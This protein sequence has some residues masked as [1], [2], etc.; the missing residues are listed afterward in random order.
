MFIWNRVRA[1]SAFLA[2][3]AVNLNDEGEELLEHDA[4]TPPPVM[5]ESD[6]V[7]TLWLSHIRYNSPKP[8]FQEE[9]RPGLPDVVQSSQEGARARSPPPDEQQIPQHQ[10]PLP[11]QPPS[12]ESLASS[13]QLK[14]GRRPQ[15]VNETADCITLSSDEDEGAQNVNIALGGGEKLMKV[16]VKV[17]PDEKEVKVNFV[18]IPTPK[19]VPDGK[20]GRDSSSEEE[21][22]KSRAKRKKKKKA[23]LLFD[24][25]SSDDESLKQLKALPLPKSPNQGSLAQKVQQFRMGKACDIYFICRCANCS[26]TKR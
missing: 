1:P 19:K 22:G 10:E 12:P 23:S 8:V 15:L 3:A 11:N 26:L 14:F 5:V 24:S 6:Q 13:V 17:M 2:A 20:R 21:L 4:P 25:D 7:Q 18:P 9:G 16:E